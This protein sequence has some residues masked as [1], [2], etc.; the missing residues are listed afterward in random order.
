[1]TDGRIPVVEQDWGPV[2]VMFDQRNETK[3]P[4]GRLRGFDGSGEA[5]PILHDWLERHRF[6]VSRIAPLVTRGLHVTQFWYPGADA[7]YADEPWIVVVTQPESVLVVWCA[8]RRNDERDTVEESELFD[9][10]DL[11]GIQ[12]HVAGALVHYDSMMETFR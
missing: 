3:A 6:S 7:W 5:I 10:D 11:E 8:G 4:S 2:L 1:M 9:S 12:K